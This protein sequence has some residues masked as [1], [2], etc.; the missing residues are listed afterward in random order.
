MW[1]SSINFEAC[2]IGVKL[3]FLSTSCSLILSKSV[4]AYN[5]PAVPRAFSLPTGVIGS[6]CKVLMPKLFISSSLSIALIKLPLSS[7]SSIISFPFKSLALKVLIFMHM[8]FAWLLRNNVLKLLLSSAKQDNDI[9][10]SI[11]KITAKFFIYS[12]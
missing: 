5:E 2:S 10:A 7:F 3:D 11:N 4:I 12:P 8:M 1:H 9:D 6:K